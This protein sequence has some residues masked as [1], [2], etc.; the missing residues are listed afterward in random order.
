VEY[1][2]NPEA[3]Q[4]KVR[5]GWVHHGDLFYADPE[6]NLYFV[7]RKSDSMRRRGENISSFEVE[8]TIEKYP[9]VAECA[10]FGVPSELGEDDVMVWVKPAAGATLDPKGLMQHCADNMAYFM[11]PRYVDVVE[12]IPRTGT[13]R[14]QKAAMKQQGVTG[15]TWDREKEIPDLKL[16]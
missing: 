9:D 7:D 14:V 16:K 8:N 1:Y 10:A 12:D 2:K 13:L 3:S 5:D 11:V 4:K 6:G 15:K